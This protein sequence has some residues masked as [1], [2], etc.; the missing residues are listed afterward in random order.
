VDAISRQYFGCQMADA[1]VLIFVEDAGEWC[2]ASRDCSQR[3]IAAPRWIDDAH[4]NAVLL[5]AMFRPMLG[6]RTY[7]L[8]P[9]AGLHQAEAFLQ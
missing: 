8:E 7:H 6:L 3:P 2:S 5:P 9:H 4:A 1:R